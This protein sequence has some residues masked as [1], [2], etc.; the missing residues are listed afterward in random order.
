MV[1]RRKR[2]ASAQVKRARRP[3]DAARSAGFTLMELL[4]SIAIIAVLISILFPALR[5]GIGA[6]RSFRCQS[7]LRSVAF[8]FAI[9]ADPDMKAARGH[10]ESRYGQR[11]FAL[12]TFIESEYRIDEFWPKSE[13]R[14][15]VTRT[16]DPSLDPMRCP[17][18][19][20]EL[21][22]RRNTPCQSGALSPA[23]NIAF[24]FNSRLDRAEIEDDNGRVRAVDVRIGPEILS[25][26]MVPLVWDVDG[27][28]AA[29]RGL[30][31]LFS[32][33]SLGS[34][35]PYSVDRYWWPGTRHQGRANF[36]LIDGSVHS[37]E[38][39]LAQS[40]WLWMYQPNP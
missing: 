13:S 19:K 36:A 10:D 22:M 32:A 2:S 6:A 14:D 28:A 15:V 20:G 11:R 33:P 40:S 12:S 4:I 37:P 16:S 21:T 17:E 9:F 8:D 18:V 30:V 26:G 5:Q 34:R 38:Q 1:G 25:K 39:P 35:G 27:E 31:P 7:N 29:L 23:Q 3:V 24:G